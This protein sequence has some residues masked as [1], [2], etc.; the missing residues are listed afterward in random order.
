M[1]K[2]STSL[3]VSAQNSSTFIKQVVAGIER[4]GSREDAS[5]S[6][7]G[8]ICEESIAPVGFEPKPSYVLEDAPTKVEVGIPESSISALSTQKQLEIIDKDLSKFDQIENGVPVDEPSLKT[9]LER[10]H[11]FPMV[12]SSTQFLE[13]CFTPNSSNS[14]FSMGN[15]AESIRA[16]S[17]RGAHRHRVSRK[18]KDVH[19]TLFVK[20]VTREFDEEM[21][22]A[23]GNRK[24]KEVYPTNSSVEASEQPC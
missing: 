7:K 5:L 13:N 20:K 10:V 12:A 9:D 14:L 1:D 15:K 22:D 21:E 24:K 8:Q 4:R 3:L 11:M 18:I 6:D 19:G 17:S 16:T 2:A 23:E